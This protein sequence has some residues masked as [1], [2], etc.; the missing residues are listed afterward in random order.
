MKATEI[1]LRKNWS[2]TP[3]LRLSE[4]EMIATAGNEIPHCLSQ[5]Q[6]YVRDMDPGSGLSESPQHYDEIKRE[7]AKKQ[8]SRD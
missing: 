7:F 6:K 1:T 5:H 3:E 8:P 2:E 4:T